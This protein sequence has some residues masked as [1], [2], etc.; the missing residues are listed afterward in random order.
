MSERK[1]AWPGT[2]SPAS[3]RREGAFGEDAWAD[4]G[5]EDWDGDAWAEGEGMEEEGAAAEAGD[6]G[7][8][9]ALKSARE[10]RPRPTS[11]R[12]PTMARTMFRRKRSASIVKRQ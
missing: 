3:E 5:E 1:R 7:R 8:M 4:S 2:D 11:R 12:V 10:R 9:R 6:G